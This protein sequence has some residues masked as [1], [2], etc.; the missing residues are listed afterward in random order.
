MK[1]SIIIPVYNVN[2]WIDECMNSVMEQ[3]FEDFEVLLINDGSTDGSEQKCVRWAEKD[4]RIRYISKE[5]EGLSQTRNLGI[6]EARGEYIAFIDSDDWVDKDF[7]LELYNAA[8]N[9]NADIVECDVCRYNDISG[10][11]MYR[12]CYGAIGIDYTKD[13]H[14][15]YGNTAI[16]KCLFK[17]ELFEKYHIHFPACHSPARAI[18]ALLIALSNKVVNVRKPMYY[19]RIFR[20]DSLSD[21]PRTILENGRAVGTQA[22]EELILNFERCG[23]SDIYKEQLERTVKYK[24]SDLLAASFHRKPDE[25]FNNMVNDYHELIRN[26]FPDGKDKTYFVVGGYNLN[27]VTWYMNILHNPSNRF[28]FSSLISI[29]NSVNNPPEFEHKNKYRKIMMDR[30]ICSKFWEML[31]KKRP[32]YL[33]IDFLEERFDMI[34]YDNGFV[35]KSDAFEEAEF[36]NSLEDVIYRNSEICNELWKKSC[37][38]FIQKMHNEYFE[39]K[40]VLI[41]NYL[42]ERVGDVNHKEFYSEINYI[43]EK[44]QILKKYYDFFE[45][46]CQDIR[47]INMAEDELYFTDKEYEYGAMPSHLN[48]IMNR[49]IAAKIEENLY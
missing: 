18:Y 38:A 45:R 33:F 10:K 6:R 19:Y 47:V 35:T 29:M 3:S 30:D 4:S 31:N 41:K 1:V 23:I 8:S 25:E 48:D 39:V 22:I 14:L 2:S 20:K 34:R 26:Y 7:L 16:W 46:N 12:S 32:E 36:R 17:R 11:K 9:T 44:N 5:N 21:K 24:L 37:L 43:Q 42:C 27:R 15:I 40:I 13:E 49:K 28:N